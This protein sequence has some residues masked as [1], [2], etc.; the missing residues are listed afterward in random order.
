MTAPAGGRPASR[1]SGAPPQWQPATDAEAAMFGALI[2][3]DR[4]RYF[5]VLATAPLYLPI[6]ASDT[7]GG[8]GGGTGQQ[9]LTWDLMGHTYLLVFTSVPAL[10]AAV[11]GIAQGYATTSYAELRA[12]WPN[13][14]W[15]LAVNPGLPIDAWVEIEA[16]QQAAAGTRPVT[17]VAD[18]IRARRRSDPEAEAGMDMYLRT[19]LDTEVLVPVSDRVAAGK[20]TLEELPWRV[21]PQYKQPTIEVFTSVEGMS[22]GCPPHVKCM[23][24]RFADLIADWP[25]DEYHLVVDPGSAVSLSLS[26]DKV[27]GLL[28]WLPKT[29]PA[30]PG[31]GGDAT[32]G[33]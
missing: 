30:G 10:A 26:G 16:V 20:V 21:A 24:R 19:L 17:A 13:P 27:P 3:D 25:G 33:E 6:F 9:F 14:Q 8:T 23:P 29:G 7:A 5:Q 15:R 4:R 32:A 12:K 28:L 22:A 1:P 31:G 2:E 11:R 18:V